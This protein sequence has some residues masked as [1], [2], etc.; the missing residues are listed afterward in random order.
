MTTAMQLVVLGGLDAQYRRDRQLAGSQ[1]RCLATHEAAC[2]ACDQLGLVQ[3]EVG[4]RR[5]PDHKPGLAS[6]REGCFVAWL[7]V[8]GS[9]FRGWSVCGGCLDD[10]AHASHEA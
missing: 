7:S 1:L 6:G 3:L 2:R 5:W 10:V 4:S 8:Q 9:G